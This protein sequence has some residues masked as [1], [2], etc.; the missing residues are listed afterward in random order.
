MYV[1]ICKQC[2]IFYVFF[3]LH[4]NELVLALKLF[5]SSL[6]SGIYLYYVLLSFVDTV[7]WFNFN[8][9]PLS[10]YPTIFPFF[11]LKEILGWGV[12]CIVKDS[13]AWIIHVPASLNTCARVLYTLKWNCGWTVHTSS[14]LP[15]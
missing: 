14:V 15:A 3:Q 9:I 6:F 10:D 13:I 1:C 11:L 8:Y 5:C 12:C 7:Y 2:T 4:I